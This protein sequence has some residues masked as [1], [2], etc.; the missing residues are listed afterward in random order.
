MILEA[1]AVGLVFAIAWRVH[2]NS[3]RA[4]Y[5]RYYANLRAEH[6]APSSD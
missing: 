5:D 4:K 6:G 1:S 3:E 2:H